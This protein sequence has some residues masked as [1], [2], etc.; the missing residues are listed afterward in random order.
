MLE[1]HQ[2]AAWI[3]NEP[4]L[5]WYHFLQARFAGRLP[6]REG[7]TEIATA[8]HSLIQRSESHAELHGSMEYGSSISPVIYD[9]TGSLDLY[10]REIVIHEPHQNQ[11]ERQYTGQISENGRVMTLHITAPDGRVTSKPIY[12]V[13]EPTL[14]T[15][16]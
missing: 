8:I 7:G 5:A 3:T 4:H 9:F 15:L 16:T 10:S 14:A 1:T 12:L 6:T 11:P 2:R 13:H